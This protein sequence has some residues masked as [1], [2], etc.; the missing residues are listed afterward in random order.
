MRTTVAL[1]T[2]FVAAILAALIPTG[3]ECRVDYDVDGLAVALVAVDLNGDN[4]LDIAAADQSSGAVVILFN[5]GD[6]TFQPAVNIPTAAGTN[7]IVAAKFTPWSSADLAVTNGAA[8]SISILYGLGDGTFEPVQ[9]ITT[10]ENP[11]SIAAGDFYE[12]GCTDLACI[13]GNVATSSLCFFFN[14]N[15]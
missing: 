15:M 10:L 13:A 7:S 9:T 5:N 4:A 11:R 2:V 6:G 14:D 8:N 12:D 1:K 3:G